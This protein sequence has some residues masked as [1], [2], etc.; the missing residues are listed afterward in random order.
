VCVCVSV[1]VCL[2][3]TVCVD[4]CLCVNV[5]VHQNFDVM[6][7]KLHVSCFCGFSPFSVT[8]IVWLALAARPRQVNR[9]LGF[10]VTLVTL[11]QLFS[12]RSLMMAAA[13]I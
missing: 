3:S 8:I 10:L 13:S 1:C 5:C 2:F 7:C 6:T 4:A 12:L 9:E 11:H